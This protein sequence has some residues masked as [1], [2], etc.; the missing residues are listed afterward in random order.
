MGW[1]GFEDIFQFLGKNMDNLK[2]TPT[3]KLRKKKKN[4]YFPLNPGC[5]N[6]GI[7]MA[8]IVIPNITG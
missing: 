1:M 3:L 6:G 2:K 7:L 5:C 8:F 4:S